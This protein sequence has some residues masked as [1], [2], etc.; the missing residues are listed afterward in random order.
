MNNIL[1]KRNDENEVQ[2]LFRIGQSKEAGTLSETWPEI[3]EA[4]N[5]ELYDSEEDYCSESV[6]RKKY[7]AYKEA[8]ENIIANEN[9][10]HELEK[11]RLKLRDERTDLQKS[12][13]EYARKESFIEVVERAMAK[14]IEPFKI[15]PHQTV[16]SDRDMIVCLSDMHTGIE[17]DNMW[18]KFNTDI[19]QKRLNSYVDS[20]IK[21]QKIQNCKVCY[22]VLGGDM[23]SGFCHKNLRLQN[24]ENV[25]EQLKIAVTYIA[26]FVKAIQDMF[27]SVKIYSVSGNHSRLMPNKDEALTGEDLD[28]LIPFCLQLK[29][30]NNK[31]ITVDKYMLDNTIGSFMTRA[32]YVFYLVHGDKDSPS[33]VA[34]NLGMMTGKIP[35]AV[36][37]GHRHKNALE[38]SGVTKIIQCGCVVGMDDYAVDKRLFGEPEQC[39]VITSNEQVVECFYNIKLD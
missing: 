4:V 11:A 30:E 18:N 9:D 23:I 36:I 5:K 34:S 37:M 29:F 26:E 2:Y 3:A 7:R 8:Y 27:E 38:T 6:Y 20:I 21:I 15:M 16:A 32:G 1:R 39:V 33:T 10:V 35:N 24:N 22:L 12:L 31:H 14:H 13:R 19:L 17:C 25:I 28:S